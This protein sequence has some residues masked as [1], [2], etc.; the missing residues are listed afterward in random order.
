MFLIKKLKEMKNLK[1]NIFSFVLLAVMSLFTISSCSDDGS[2]SGTGQPPVISR[3]S[4]SVD[5]NGQP[6]PLESIT[7]GYANNMYIIEGTGFKTV[8]KI[9]FNDTDTSFNPTLVT[10]THIFVTI[11]I[12]T[13]YANASDKLRVI[14]EFGEAEYDF[15]VAPPAPVVHSFNPINT[16]DGGE[17]TIY[18]NFFLNPI[19]NV[20]DDATATVTSSTLTEIHAVLPP[21][22]Q[23]K[24]I[25][26]TTI[27]GTTPYGT[28]I[29][30]GIYDDDFYSPWT[31]E[32]WNNHEFVTDITKSAQ[33]LKFIKKAMGAWDNIQGNWPWVDQLSAYTGI[34][35][36]IKTSE[37]GT[38]K[39]C[40]NGNWSETYMI[41]TTTEWQ[42][43]KY[44]WADLGNPAA[45]Q[46][47]FTFQNMSKNS[48]GDGIANT[49]Y[50]DNYS[51]TVD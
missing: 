33:G 27:S 25:S 8:K 6:V 3:V 4:A 22:S 41:T 28:A 9:Y 39:F 20:G 34:K 48:A 23:L 15:V 7:M 30:T 5:E 43:V 44:T 13:P 32:S 19:V 17:I 10:D 29:G 2:N 47:I 50:L 37:P 24:K 14:T 21:G 38:M 42:E 49:I 40:F 18:G 1:I 46:N 31:I 26:V 35:F 45:L 12:N 51:Y 11:N 16:P 36:Y